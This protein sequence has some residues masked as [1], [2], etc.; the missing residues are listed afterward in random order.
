VNDQSRYEW[1]AITSTGRRSALI[2]HGIWDTSP[3]EQAMSEA[4]SVKIQKNPKYLELARRRGR[5]ALTLS[6]IVC[7]IFYG[8]IL[9]IAFTP[10]ILTAPISANSVIPLGLP[11]G[12]GVIVACCLLTGIYVYEANQVF[13]PM[14][15][16][17]VDEAHK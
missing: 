16:Q 1:T 8:F 6:I 2:G 7:V 15:K 5:L 3:Q 13:D 11:L 17:I 9:M 12:V 4:I 10:D 14:F